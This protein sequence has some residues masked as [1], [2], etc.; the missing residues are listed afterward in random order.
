MELNYFPFF[1][2]IK[3]TLADITFKSKRHGL[4]QEFRL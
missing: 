2:M 3:K 4:M 1:L